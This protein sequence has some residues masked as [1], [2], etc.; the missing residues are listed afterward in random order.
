MTAMPLPQ[1][2]LG[3]AQNVLV[4]AEGN[5]MRISLQWNLVNES[6]N[7]VTSNV[8]GDEGG[9]GPALTTITDSGGTQIFGS[10]ITQADEMMQFL[11]SVFQ[12]KGIEYKYSITIPSGSDTVKDFFRFGAIERVSITK[13]GRAPVT[14]RVN[15]VFVAGD[16]V[17]IGP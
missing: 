12:N 16:L 1:A 11:T 9:A 2:E 4:K 10:T 15:L 7:V 17:A 6:S 8:G 14:W 3:D 13:T 5:A